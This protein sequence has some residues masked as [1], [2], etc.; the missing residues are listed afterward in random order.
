MIL[1][2]TKMKYKINLFAI[3][4]S[5]FLFAQVSTTRINDFRLGMKKTELEK[6]IGKTIQLKLSDGYPIENSHIVHKGIVY[7]V[8][9]NKHY[10][11][12]G[13]ESKDFIIH[14]VTSRDRS[15]KTL[16]G[17]SLGSTFD[18]VLNKYKNNN[19]SIYDSWDDNGNRDKS[20]RRFVIDDYDFGSQL[21]IL[22]KNGKVTEFYISYNEGC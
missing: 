20:G 12:N 2:T 9:F 4:F 22:I 13:N 17:I 16:S 21:M 11:D 15:L 6:I 10:D 3:L 8:S 1:K 14:S 5:S 7:E 18:E 19:I